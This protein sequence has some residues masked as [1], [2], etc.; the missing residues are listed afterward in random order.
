MKEYSVEFVALENEIQFMV[1]NKNPNYKS[2]HD[3]R[4]RYN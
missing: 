3:E 4:R 1:K 2:K